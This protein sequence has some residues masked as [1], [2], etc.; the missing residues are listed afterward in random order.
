M[1]LERGEVAWLV[2]T[3]EINSSSLCHESSFCSLSQ[4]DSGFKVQASFWTCHLVW[5]THQPTFKY[6]I[7]YQISFLGLLEFLLSI[8]LVL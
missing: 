8:V 5:G 6:S 1:N 7:D 4:V 3:L 2:L